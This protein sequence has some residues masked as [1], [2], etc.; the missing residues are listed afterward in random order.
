[1]GRTSRVGFGFTYF[2]RDSNTLLERDYQGLRLGA[3]AEY[4]F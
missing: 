4:G 3:T 2:T 1:M